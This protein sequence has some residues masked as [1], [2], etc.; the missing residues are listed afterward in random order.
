MTAPA[1]SKQ[2]ADA[3]RSKIISG[4]IK[5]GCPLE[6]GRNIAAG[7]SVSKQVIESA[8][9]ILEHEGLIRREP[10]KKAV[11]ISSGGRLLN[12]TAFIALDSSMG[13]YQLEI[14]SKLESFLFS[15]KVKSTVS[16]ISREDEE[17]RRQD[18]TLP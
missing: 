17:R 14:F 16:M 6:S 3:L 11:V 7:L 5:E 1:K 18:K 13:A 8:L 9:D 2:L 12:K 4:E 15:R 10:R